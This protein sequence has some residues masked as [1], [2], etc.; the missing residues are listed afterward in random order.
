[1][2]PLDWASL[3]TNQMQLKLDDSDKFS[4]FNKVCEIGIKFLYQ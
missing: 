1:V 3:Y 2:E 4:K